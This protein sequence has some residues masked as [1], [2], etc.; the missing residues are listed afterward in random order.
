MSKLWANSGVD[1]PHC[2]PQSLNIGVYS[3]E[4]NIVIMCI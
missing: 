1:I 2:P 3:F 4:S